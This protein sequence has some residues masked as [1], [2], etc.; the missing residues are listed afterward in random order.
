MINLAQN[1]SAF[2]REYLPLE[3]RACI[4]TSEAYAY[5]FQLLV[6]FAAIKTNH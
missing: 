2:L 5:T 1:L 3:R 4:N 6:K